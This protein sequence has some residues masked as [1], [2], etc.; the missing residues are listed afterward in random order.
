M[1]V[2]LN[3]MFI[4]QELEYVLVRYKYMEGKSARNFTIFPL[5]SPSAHSEMCC[6]FF[7]GGMGV[8]G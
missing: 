5:S 1:F 8:E 4:S 3:F 2:S 7:L 6:P